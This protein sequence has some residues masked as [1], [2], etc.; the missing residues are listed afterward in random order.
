MCAA[1]KYTHGGRTRYEPSTARERE[2]DDTLLSVTE[3]HNSS[4]GEEAAEF[5]RPWF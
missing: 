1:V 3:K 5:L 4:A 2:P